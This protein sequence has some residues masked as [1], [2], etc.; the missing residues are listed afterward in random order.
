MGG[1]SKIKLP[2]LTLGPYLINAPITSYH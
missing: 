1:T 2:F